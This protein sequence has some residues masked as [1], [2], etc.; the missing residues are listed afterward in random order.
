MKKIS[1]FA[2][3]I[4]LL[5]MGQDGCEAPPPHALGPPNFYCA[6]AVPS[7]AVEMALLDRFLQAL[8][9]QM[10]DTIVGGTPSTDRRATWYINMIG[11]GSCTG[12]AIGPHTVLTAA[13]CLAENP[14]IDKIGEIRIF[15]DPKRDPD[16]YYTVSSHLMN[17]EYKPH[18]KEADL[19]LLYFDEVIPGPYVKD[20]YN[21]K[22]NNRCS[23]MI[24]QGWGKTETDPIPCSDG[25][26]FCLRESKYMVDQFANNMQTLIT[27]QRTEG[28]ICFGDSGGP[29]Y[30]TLNGQDDL[31]LAG[32]TSWTQTGDCKIRSGHVN[33]DHFRTWVLQ[34]FDGPGVVGFFK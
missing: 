26:K 24:A 21:Q 15:K 28:G 34:N 29:L 11:V 13:H 32:I 14:W 23:D 17:S 3:I 30:A 5:L 19:A 20:I 27:K 16:T 6:P 1:I 33:V 4:G 9:D 2:A 22:L 8:K 7:P 31:Y 25:D 10:P 18:S 12:V